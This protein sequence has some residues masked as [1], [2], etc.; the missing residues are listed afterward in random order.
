MTGTKRRETPLIVVTDPNQHVL[1]KVLDVSTI[2]WFIFENFRLRRIHDVTY[3]DVKPSSIFANSIKP[4]KDPLF[5]Y[6]DYCVLHLY[7]ANILHLFG[8]PKFELWTLKGVSVILR[9]NFENRGFFNRWRY[10]LFNSQLLNAAPQSQTD[11][12]FGISVVELVKPSF[13]QSWRNS[14]IMTGTP[15]N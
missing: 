4:S 11:S 14:K 13:D 5:L 2:L 10:T 7:F 12:I 9:S 1:M 6:D 8:N 15:L 3:I